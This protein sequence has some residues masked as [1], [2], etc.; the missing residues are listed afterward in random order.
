LWF[1]AFGWRDGLLVIL[2][3]DPGDLAGGLWRFAGEDPDMS[4]TYDTILSLMRTAMAAWREADHVEL[5]FLDPDT[6][7]LHDLNP[8]S[9]RPDGRPRVTLS[10]HDTEEWPEEWLAAAASKLKAAE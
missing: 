9:I 6:T 8:I 4:T 2:R 1:P 5:E 3:H 7:M 10:M